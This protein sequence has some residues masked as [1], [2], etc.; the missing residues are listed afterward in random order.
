[1]MDKIE[2]IPMGKGIAGAAAERMEPVSMCNLQTD[3]TGVARPKAKKTNVGGNIAVPIDMGGLLMG[4]LGIGKLEPYEFTAEETKDLQA[5]ASQ[6][7][8][9]W[10][11]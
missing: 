4:T 11:G 10:I 7:A 8:E 9:H 3:T 6:I 2:R 1:M 5:I